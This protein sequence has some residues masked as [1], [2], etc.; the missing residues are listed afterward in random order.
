MNG[1]NLVFREKEKKNEPSTE[2]IL[3]RLTKKAYRIF[4]PL[5]ALV[6]TF[7]FTFRRSF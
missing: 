6:S 3:C 5:L 1:N 7:F 2:E 4:R